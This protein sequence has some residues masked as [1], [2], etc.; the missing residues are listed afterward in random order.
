MKEY[1]ILIFLSLICFSSYGQGYLEIANK[2]FNKADYACAISNYKEAINRASSSSR[3]IIEQKI[4]KS[5]SCQKLTFLADNAYSNSDYTTAKEQYKRILELNPKDTFAKARIKACDDI[6][7]PKPQLRKAT[8]YDLI[9]IWNNKYGINPERRKKLIAAGID[10]DNAQKR[11]NAGECKPIEDKDLVLSTLTSSLS[12]P[13]EGGH[14]N[15]SV[16]TN[17]TNYEISFLP[18]WCKVGSKYSSTFSIVCEPNQQNAGRSDWFKVKVGTKEVKITVLQEG[19][20][21]DFSS[22]PSKTSKVSKSKRAR[23]RCFNCPYYRD[24]I[25]LKFAFVSDSDDDRGQ[26]FGILYKHLFKYGIGLRTGLFIEA[27]PSFW[28]SGPNIIYMPFHF[29]YRINI[30]KQLSIFGYGGIGLNLI[31]NVNGY[32]LPTTIDY[33][34]GLQIFIIEI[35]IGENSQISKHRFHDDG[36]KLPHYK[37]IEIGVSVIFP[38]NK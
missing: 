31:S 30:A 9:D 19:K 23:D 7:F 36:H 2:C 32:P 38:L 17:A 6:L 35:N 3:H 26:K 27:I 13:S 29:E 16:T 33:G 5:E 15:I 8:C 20:T 11:I 21:N 28:E 37:K 14:A 12:F 10:P 24:G 25:G 34:A 1:F 22:T 18:S 4:V